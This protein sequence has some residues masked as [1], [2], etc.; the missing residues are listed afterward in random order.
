MSRY[1]LFEIQEQ[2]SLSKVRVLL[3]AAMCSEME[4]NLLIVVGGGKGGGADARQKQA[5]ATGRMG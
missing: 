1:F 2:Q 3:V 5:V 4:G